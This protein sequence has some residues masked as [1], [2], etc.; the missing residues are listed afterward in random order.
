MSDDVL[1]RIVRHLNEQGAEM[2][3]LK[4]ILRGLVA[5]VIIADP[6]FA[7]EQLEQMKADALGAL[8]RAP[9]NPVNNPIEEQHAV[10][11]A[12]QHIERFFREL[13]VAVSI[14]RNRAGQSGR[15]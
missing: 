14:M 13:A 9:M 10:E 4:I 8:K 2:T 5:R 11:L 12:I 15:N 1:E 3:A 7:E 6:V